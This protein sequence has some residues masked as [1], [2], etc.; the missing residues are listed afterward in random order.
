MNHRIIKAPRNIH[1]WRTMMYKP[2]RPRVEQHDYKENTVFCKFNAK[3]LFCP[4]CH[5]KAE[6]V[7]K[8]SFTYLDY[9]YFFTGCRRYPHCDWT[10][11]DEPPTKI[12]DIAQ[13]NV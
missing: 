2:E 10:N 3:G 1:E 4:W 8:Y 6:H 13:K 11:G 9:E 7:M 12:V 5:S